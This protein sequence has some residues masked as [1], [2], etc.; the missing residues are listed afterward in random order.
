MYLPPGGCFCHCGIIPLHDNLG[1]V[2][3]CGG[4]TQPIALGGCAGPYGLRVLGLHAPCLTSSFLAA[5]AI[6]LGFWW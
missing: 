6:M 2:M 3:C 1:Q 5:V 4:S